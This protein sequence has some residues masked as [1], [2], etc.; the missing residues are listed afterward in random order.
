MSQL[1]TNSQ[2][3]HECCTLPPSLAFWDAVSQR[4]LNIHVRYHLVKSAV[5][6]LGSML[7]FTVTTEASLDLVPDQGPGCK[8]SFLR[9]QKSQQL[10][11]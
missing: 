10:E 3:D 1:H 2:A 4:P 6:L 8:E 7:V 11:K 5:V 9:G